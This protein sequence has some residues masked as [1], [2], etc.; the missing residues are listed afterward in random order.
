MPKQTTQDLE[1]RLEDLL[2]EKRLGLNR[3]YDTIAH[4]FLDIEA[5][6]DF[7]TDD[8]NVIDSD[9]QVLDNI[10]DEARER[11][12]EIKLNKPFTEYNEEEAI[13]ILKTISEIFKNLGFQYQETHLLNDGLKNKKSNCKYYT[14]TY[15]GIADVLDLPL[16]AVIVPRHLF[17][18]WHFDGDGYINWET[19]A[20]EERSDEHYELGYDI[21]EISVEKGVF[22]RSLDKKE[23]Y[24]AVYDSKGITLWDLGR[25]HEAM[26]N[27][28]K[29]IE[30]NPNCPFPYNNKGITLHMFR[31]Y[32]EAIRCYD[33]ALELDS[34]APFTYN[35]KGV[36]LYRLGEYEKAI[37]NYDRALE[38]DP[39]Y[40]TAIDNKQKALAKLNE[41]EKL[42]KD[43]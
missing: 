26:E 14:M 18:R 40:N 6:T 36:A 4:H 11:I 37:E 9:Y 41:M 32:E 29:S 1:A 31:E 16:K 33:T 13:G 23:A 3:K 25:Y 19:T 28:D 22:L 20:A 2:P 38:L 5:E 35:N 7:E 17:V 30:L 10:I 43:E 39:N 24:S 8:Y 12:S 34:N 27:H 15:L 42:K 21:S